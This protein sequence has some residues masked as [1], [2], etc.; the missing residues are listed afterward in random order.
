MKINLKKVASVLASAVMF[1][2]TIGFAAAAW[3]E[4][5]VKSGAGDA[6]IVVGTNVVATDMSAA[7]DLGTSLN[8]KVTSTGA[9]TV[10][11]DSIQLEK[12][13]DKFNLVN[14]ADSFYSTLD[15]SGKLKI[16]DC[17]E[18]IIDYFVNFRLGYYHKRK[19]Y[20]LERMN[21][22]L[23]ILSNRGK[24]IKA[25]LDEKLKVNNVSKVEIIKGIELMELDKIDDSFDYLLR[26]PIYSLTKEVF[27]KLK[28]DFVEKKTEIQ[29][30][31]ETNPKDMYVS[32]LNELKKKFK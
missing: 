28:A 19:S 20:L 8:A 27:D 29:K 30:T 11:G 24:F 16:F 26:M 21:R 18:D 7:T 3:P 9:T 13:S 12:S 2:S 5:F 23:K 32:D 31:E 6:A 25:I 17:T 1:G 4:P 15:E 22:E 10:T 14:T